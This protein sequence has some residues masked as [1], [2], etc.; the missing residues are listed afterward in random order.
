MWRQLVLVGSYSGRFLALDAAT[1][2]ERWRFQARGPI[3]GSAVVIGD[4]VYVSTLARQTYALAADSGK[5]LWT[6]PEG[7]YAAAI[8][9][10]GRLYLVGYTRLYAMVPAP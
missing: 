2:E 1:G 7:K 8:A 10:A 6:F 4:V 9:G 3:S 5:L